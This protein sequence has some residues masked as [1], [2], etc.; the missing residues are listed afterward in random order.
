MTPLATVA[1]TGY[2]VSCPGDDTINLGYDELDRLTSESNPR[3]SVCP[4]SRNLDTF[5]LGQV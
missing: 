3:G 5:G 1:G 4:A 2:Q